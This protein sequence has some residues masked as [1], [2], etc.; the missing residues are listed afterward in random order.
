MSLKTFHRSVL[1]PH[2]WNM[3]MFGYLRHVLIIGIISW[4]WW[5]L[6]WSA[7]TNPKRKILPGILKSY[8]EVVARP[9]K[10]GNNYFLLKLCFLQASLIWNLATLWHMLTFNFLCSAILRSFSGLLGFLPIVFSVCLHFSWYLLSLPPQTSFFLQFFLEQLLS[11]HMDFF[12]LI[13]TFPVAVPWIC[14]YLFC[15]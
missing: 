3:D 14:S 4:S 10:K 11:F 1:Y 7:E 9:L 8:S 12:P 2:L 5:Q 6:F 15:C 13:I